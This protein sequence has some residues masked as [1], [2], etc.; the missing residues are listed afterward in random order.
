MCILAFSTIPFPT[1]TLTFFINIYFS[2]D[3]LENLQNI[4]ISSVL[5]FKQFPP[6]T[7]DV[8]RHNSPIPPWNQLL[9]S[10]IFFSY[11]TILKFSNPDDNKKSG[12]RRGR[13][14]EWFRNHTDILRFSPA[15]HTIIITKHVDTFFAVYE[16]PLSTA[17]Y[18]QANPC[19]QCGPLILFFLQ[20]KM[21]KKNPYIQ[22]KQMWT[23]NRLESKD[24]FVFPSILCFFPATASTITHK[25]KECLLFHDL[26]FVFFQHRKQI[27]P[28]Y[29]LLW[30]SSHWAVD[31]PVVPW[32]KSVCVP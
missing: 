7:E 27:H 17:W 22:I 21:K 9:S 11:N 19:F 12:Q 14:C 28:F 20:K 2:R 6:I 5:V 31:T 3:V 15:C 1:W 24:T 8:K 13:L 10:H 23:P 32:W 4:M 29:S 16:R 26:H 25:Y 30:G 18:L